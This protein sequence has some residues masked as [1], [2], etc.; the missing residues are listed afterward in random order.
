MRIWKNPE[1]H[2][3]QILEETVGVAAKQVPMSTEYHFS[4]EL[5]T[6]L[7][8][9]DAMGVVSHGYFFTY[10]DVGRMDY[11]RN[12]GLADSGASSPLPGPARPIRDFNNL[13]VRAAC[14][15]RSPARFDDQL[16][17]HVRIA[18]LGHTSFRFEFRIVHKRENRVVAEGESVHVAI[19]E[20]TWRPAEVPSAFREI[21]RAFEGAALE[22]T[23]KP[24]DSADGNQGTGVE[25]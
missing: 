24:G 2:G 10:M 21:V 25:V 5:R 7:P 3:N 18:S 4:T 12:L 23:W 11:L 9:T 1:I 6:R 14:N 16:V 15:Y 20:T 17:I 19:D 8:E 22:E 13:V